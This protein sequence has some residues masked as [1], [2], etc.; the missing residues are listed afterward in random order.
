MIYDQKLP[1]NYENILKPIDRKQNGTE[2]HLALKA[3][4]ESD[5]SHDYRREHNRNP[6]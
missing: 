2:T 4:P 6:K 5:H 3:G 1:N